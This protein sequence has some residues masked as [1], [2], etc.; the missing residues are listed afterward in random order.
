MKYSTMIMP[1]LLITAC[2]NG[3]V[4]APEN[5]VQTKKEDETMFRKLTIASGPARK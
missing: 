1:L 4:Q 3:A 2:T 5:K